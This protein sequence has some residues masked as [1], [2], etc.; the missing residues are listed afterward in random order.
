MLGFR[1]GKG[2]VPSRKDIRP[3]PVGSIGKTDKYK[4]KYKQIRKLVK[5][6]IFENAALCDQIAILQEKTLL[7][8]EERSFLFKKLQQYNPSGDFEG[9]RMPIPTSIDNV[10]PKKPNTNKKK[11]E[12]SFI[13][14]PD[15]FKSSKL[16]KPPVPRKKKIVKSIPLDASGKPIF[17]I[18]LGDF[19][20]HSL[21]E[22][23][24]KPDY[25]TEDLIYPIGY[26]ST[27]IYGSLKD[28]E[29]QCVYTCKVMDGGSAPRFEIVADTDLDVPIMSASIDQC[30]SML[31]SHINAC[32]GTEVVNA[33]GRGADFFGIS[34]PTIHHLIQ[35][36]P[37]VRKCKG[38][39][40]T[41]FEINPNYEYVADE[42]EASLSYNAL[43][44]SILF[45]KSHLESMIKHESSSSDY[46]E[47]VNT[48]RNML[49]S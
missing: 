44:R 16:K 46:L 49:L 36:S 12:K 6:L 37:G 30:H 19:T 32:L 13:E 40:W 39:V 43:L 22:V 1:Q 28:P 45:S 41:K 8:I 18:V 7:L 21:G 2:T 4:T 11:S 34:H 24:E 27:R 23:C 26:C 38:Y 33:K 42:M 31:L 10:I 3:G 25:H 29:K 14:S 9:F 47:D 48:L 5:E 17:P 15:M 20:V 35:G